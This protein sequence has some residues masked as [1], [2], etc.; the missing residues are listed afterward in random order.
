MPRQARLPIDT[1]QPTLVKQTVTETV[2]HP[3]PTLKMPEPSG[4][5]PDINFWFATLTAQ[6][7]T[8]DFLYYLYRLDTNVI[9][10]EENLDNRARGTMLDKLERQ[11]VIDIAQGPFLEEQSRY[12]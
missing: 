2:S 8:D 12:G 4:K 6:E 1:P 7:R 11:D 5:K 3:A 9:I 10:T